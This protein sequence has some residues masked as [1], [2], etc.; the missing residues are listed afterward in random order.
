MH[1]EKCNYINDEKEREAYLELHATNA[2]S[3][4]THYK[5]IRS[6]MNMQGVSNVQELA[7]NCFEEEV[8]SDAICQELVPIS[9][10][11]LHSRS[12]HF[13]CKNLGY[14]KQ[15][16]ISIPARYMFVHITKYTAG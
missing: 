13:R 15:N 1:C 9:F 12:H 2:V 14:S 4:E 10:T 7:M 5:L 3:D 11:D 8:V 6:A 16:F